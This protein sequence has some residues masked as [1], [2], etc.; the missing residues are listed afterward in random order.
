MQAPE[1]LGKGTNAEALMAR[2]QRWD[3]EQYVTLSQKKTSVCR[4]VATFAT[5]EKSSLVTWLRPRK[6]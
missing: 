3:T 1:E 4:R 5:P 2:L 6:Q